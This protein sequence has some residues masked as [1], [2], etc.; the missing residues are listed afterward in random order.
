MMNKLVGIIFGNRELV[1]TDW[2]GL[3]LFCI[4]IIGTGMIC[5]KITLN[6]TKGEKPE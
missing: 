4:S 3:S 1:L 2:I 6:N 5:I